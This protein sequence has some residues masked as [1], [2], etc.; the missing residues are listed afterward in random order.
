[1]KNKEP[2]YLNYR[3]P[4]DEQKKHHSWLRSTSFLPP[5]FS[6]YFCSNSTFYPAFF[7]GKHASFATPAQPVHKKNVNQQHYPHPTTRPGF[8]TTASYWG[9]YLWH[10]CWPRCK[11][12]RQTL[13]FVPR[14]LTPV[15]IH[16]WFPFPLLAHILLSQAV[17][18]Y[19]YFQEALNYTTRHTDI[20]LLQKDRK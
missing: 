13:C 5:S 11:L 14:A 4:R 16:D 6:I 2:N 17:E 1:M 19:K 20:K 15:R 8:S 7:Q 18:Q 10:C 12:H 9:I 3:H